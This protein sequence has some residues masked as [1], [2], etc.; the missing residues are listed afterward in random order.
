MN[1][2]QNFNISIA[3]LKVFDIENLKNLLGEDDNFKLK[4]EIDEIF[5]PQ[6]NDFTSLIP[7]NSA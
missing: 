4:Q 7:P 6:K 2:K 3:K 5:S 1:T